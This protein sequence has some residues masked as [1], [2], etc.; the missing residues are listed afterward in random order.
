LLDRYR[1]MDAAH[2]DVITDGFNEAAP[3]VIFADE[4]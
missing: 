2:T 4:A 3:A 1:F